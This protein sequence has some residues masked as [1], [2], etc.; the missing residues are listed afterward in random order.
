MKGTD[1]VSVITIIANALVALVMP[2]MVYKIGQLEKNTN[3]IKDALVLST[4]NE[5]LARGNLEGRAAEKA[6]AASKDQ[7]QTEGKV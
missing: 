5:A 3:S 1:W 2:W 7:K 4:K 6:E